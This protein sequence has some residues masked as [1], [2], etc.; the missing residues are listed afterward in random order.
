MTDEEKTL[1]SYRMGRAHE[2]ID[3]AKTLFDAGHVNSYV[4]RLYYA[5]FYAVSAL[6]LTKNLS[7]SKHGYLRSLM[8]REL[9]KTG[10]IPKEL[11]GHFDLL[12]DSRMKGDYVDFARFEADEVVDWLEETQK[13]ISHVDTLLRELT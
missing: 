5:C 12:F 6:L 9:V 3:E 11:G 13:F 2:A 8:H 10:L 4:N 7:T 1:I